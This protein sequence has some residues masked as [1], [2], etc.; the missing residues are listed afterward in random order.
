MGRWSTPRPGRFT[1][2]KERRYTL[3]RRLGGHQYRTGRVPPPEL[4][5]QTVQPVANRYTEYAIVAHPKSGR[6]QE[7]NK[8]SYSRADYGGFFF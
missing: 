5:P 8:T 2:G 1:P 3:Y 4:D 6:K 7:T